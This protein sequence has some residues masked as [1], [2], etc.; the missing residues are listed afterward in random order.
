[1][2]VIGRLQEPEVFLREMQTVSSWRQS[3]LH[4]T[5]LT[6]DH[7][8]LCYLQNHFLSILERDWVFSKRLESSFQG[9][10]WKKMESIKRRVV[11]RVTGLYIESHEGLGIV[12]S[13]KIVGDAVEESSS[14]LWRAVTRGARRHVLWASESGNQPIAWRQMGISVTHPTDMDCAPILFQA[15]F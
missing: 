6:P 14:V 9:G 8:V 1:M 12:S 2:R 7:F 5:Y 3:N 10:C 13:V 4:S 15:L 11:R